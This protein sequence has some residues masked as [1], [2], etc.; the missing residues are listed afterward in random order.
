MKKKAKSPIP[1]SPKAVRPPAI[2]A[3][4]V[5][6][7]VTDALHAC[8]ARNSSLRTLL[9]ERERYTLALLELEFERHQGWLDGTARGALRGAIDRLKAAY[10]EDSEKLSRL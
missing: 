3:P 1:S 8:E 5:D 10:T 6:H 2:V 4:I 7:R 9:E